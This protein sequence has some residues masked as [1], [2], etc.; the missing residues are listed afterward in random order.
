MFVDVSNANR[1]A[2]MKESEFSRIAKA[3]ADP[4]RFE[5]LKVIIDAG[6]ISCGEVA[7]RFPVSQS[8]IS[9]HLRLLTEAGLVRVRRE[10][11]FGYFSPKPATFEKYIEALGSNLRERVPM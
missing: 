5:I 2:L 11:Q 8:T 9:H 10:G 6:E 4:R 1:N 3:L 7:A